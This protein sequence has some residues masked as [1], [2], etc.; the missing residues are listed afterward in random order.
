M[1]NNIRPVDEWTAVHILVGLALG[2]GEIDVGTALLGAVVY[3]AVEQRVERTD[4]G[5][6]FFETSGPESDANVA[7]DL[8]AFG[9]AFW[10]GR[11]IR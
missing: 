9:L 5:A 11:V 3:E 8:L 1:A 10:I 4:A 7:T 6:E 2:L